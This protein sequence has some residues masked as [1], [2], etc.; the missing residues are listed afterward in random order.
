MYAKMYVVVST[1]AQ[2]YRTGVSSQLPWNNPGRKIVI[3]ADRHSRFGLFSHAGE[4][5]DILDCYLE[6]KCNTS[7]VSIKES[8]SVSQLT[9][10]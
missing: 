10:F 3:P 6:L 5:D 7:L 2:Y 9:P 4:L 1:Q 8:S